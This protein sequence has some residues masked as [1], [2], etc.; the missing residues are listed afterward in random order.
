VPHHPAPPGEDK[1]N[2]G[3]HAPF[4]PLARF[5][6]GPVGS[7]LRCFNIRQLSLE[8][9]E[10]FWIEGPLCATQALYLRPYLNNDFHPHRIEYFDGIHIKMKRTVIAASFGRL[11]PLDV[12]KDGTRDNLTCILKKHN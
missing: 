4:P 2:P 10:T 12:G 3:K 8:C 5:G 9:S 6:D 7:K 1:R 11:E